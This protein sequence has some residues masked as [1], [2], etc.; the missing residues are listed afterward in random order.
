MII[1]DGYYIAESSMNKKQ[2][3]HFEVIESISTFGHQSFSK[4][5]KDN[6]EFYGMT[7]ESLSKSTNMSSF[8]LSCLVKGN[9]K[10][11]KH[12]VDLIKKRLHI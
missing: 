9:A 7:I 11:E 3:E 10:F 5:I 6:L 4:Q 8:R 2:I 12:E 1:E